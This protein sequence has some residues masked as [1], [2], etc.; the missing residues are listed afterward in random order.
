MDRVGFLLEGKILFCVLELKNTS[1]AKDKIN[2]MVFHPKSYL[3]QMKVGSPFFDYLSLSRD[4]FST[5][6]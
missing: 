3:L 6:N 4:S 1:A 5:G 2:S